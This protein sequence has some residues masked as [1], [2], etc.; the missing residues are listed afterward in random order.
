[1]RRYRIALLAFYLSLVVFLGLLIAGASFFHFVWFPLVLSVVPMSAFPLWARR[2]LKPV[3]RVVTKLGVAF[4]SR[5]LRECI[6]WRTETAAAL[7]LVMLWALL[8]WRTPYEWPGA[9]ILSW[10]AVGILPIKIILARSPFPLPPEQVEEYHRWGE[11]S[12]AAFM[13]IAD[14]WRWTCV[15]IIAMGVIERGFPAILTPH[16]SRPLLM[17]GFLA[18]FFGQLIWMGRIGYRVNDMGRALPPPGTWS[19]PSGPVKPS[20]PGGRIWFFSYLGGMVLLIVLLQPW[21]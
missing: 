21:L 5:P 1:M 9:V 12:R 3:P 7:A 13:R 16:W 20:L 2:A 4:E 6:A 8:L 10:M 14:I 19:G 18:A 15:A 17:Y 11:A